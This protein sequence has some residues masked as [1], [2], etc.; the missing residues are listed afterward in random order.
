MATTEDVLYFAIRQ[1]DGKEWIDISAW[2][3]VMQTAVSTAASDNI[4]LPVQWVRDNPVVRV[5]RFKL[6]EIDQ[7]AI[8]EVKHHGMV[9]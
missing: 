8:E 7:G 5:G 4:V 9:N 2:G 1:C 6:V 3:Y